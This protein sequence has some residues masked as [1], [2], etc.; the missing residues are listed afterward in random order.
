[1]NA[2]LFLLHAFSIITFIALILPS[3]FAR[4]IEK[5]RKT[6]DT[7]TTHHHVAHHASHGAPIGVMGDHMLVVGEWMFSLRQMRM[8]MSGNKIGSDN[9]SDA[10]ILNIPN[11]NAM[12]PPNLRVV[13]QHME[14]DMT[15]FG[16]MYAPNTDLTLM[17]MA[18][19]L[20]HISEPTRPY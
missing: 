14:M 17:A 9:A 3:A 5:S 20:I 8:K 2:R 13:P 18:L 16:V 19:S 7:A 11:T 1:M 12:M 4:D 10:E 15:M 6:V